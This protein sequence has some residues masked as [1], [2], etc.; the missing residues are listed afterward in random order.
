VELDTLLKDKAAQ[1]SSMMLV[2]QNKVIFLTSCAVER[3]ATSKAA[4]DFL[5][6]ELLSAATLL[7]LSLSG[8]YPV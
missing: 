4:S 8:T 5:S 7:A 6:E 1:K 2:A 3:S